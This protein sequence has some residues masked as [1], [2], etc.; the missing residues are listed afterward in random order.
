MT[1]VGSLSLEALQSTLSE[2]GTPVTSEQ[3][4]QL[5]AYLELLLRWNARTNLTAVREPLA[6]VKRHFAD[7]L[8]CARKIPPS[9][10][11]VLDFGSGGGFPGVPLAILHPELAV[12]LA[13]SQS[14]KAAFLR[15]VV[16]T[17][18]LTAQIWGQRVEGM[19]A[20][21]RFDCVTLRAVD[22][23]LL[24][25]PLAA[26][27]LALGGTLL[28]F[29][30]ERLFESVEQALPGWHWSQTALPHSEQGLLLIASR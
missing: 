20:E 18:G 3:A 23:M 21:Q 9:T 24:A 12:T 1:P 17:L 2:S 11:T 6:I 7:S 27:R 16:R 29:S 26:E 4:R 8:F 30:T 13:E 28:A 25:C 22:Q 15:E 14:K 19:P 5:L 10:Q